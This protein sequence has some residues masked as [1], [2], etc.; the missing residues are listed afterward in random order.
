MFKF[1]SVKKWLLW[2]WLGSITILSSLWIQVKIDVAINEWFGQFY[3]MIQKALASP[4]AITI[5]EYWESLISFLTLAGTY[6]AV[7]VLVSFFT[8]HF[9]FRWRTA[10][11]EWYH[12]VYDQA[13]QIEGAA[14]RVQEDTIKFTKIMES[15]GTSLVEAIMVLIQFV[16]IL[17]GLS[18]GIPI[19]LFGE[20]QFGLVTGALLWTLGG[21]IFLIGLGWVLKLVGVEY[22]LQKK[23]AAYRKILVIAEDDI[24]VR[25]KTIEELFNDVRGIHFLSYLKY[26]YFN[27][28]RIAYLQ[29][30]VLSA[31]VFL[32]PAIVAGVVTLG[33]MQQI[34][35][36]FG[37]VEGS[38]QYL[39]KAW[40]A[41]IE[42]ASVYKRLKEFENQ[43]YIERYTKNA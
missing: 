31:Y 7:A 28:G 17:L 5:N 2:S 4:N 23:E 6:V 18:I 25:P 15:L 36:A 24:N 33:V 12:S 13:R 19:F 39:L 40:P 30:N 43:I 22:D 32:G 29:A 1:F 20:W 34:I 16:P 21:T 26:L 42:L 10:M 9:L 38:M 27:I 11:V 41:I 3:D 35:R 37:R 14:Q 8:A